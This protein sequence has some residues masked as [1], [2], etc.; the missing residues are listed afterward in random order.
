MGDFEPH[1]CETIWK[2]WKTQKS[3]WCT[4]PP[5]MKKLDTGQSDILVLADVPPPRNWNWTKHE[6]YRKKNYFKRGHQVDFSNLPTPSIIIIWFYD[7]AGNWWISISNGFI[8][9]NPIHHPSPAKKN[10][11][12]V[13]GLC[14]TSDDCPGWLMDSNPICH[15]SPAKNVK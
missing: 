9:L 6:C 3:C 13:F 14:S 8:D 7:W 11:M 2:S 5:G 12:L 10:K 1:W 4:L 15:P